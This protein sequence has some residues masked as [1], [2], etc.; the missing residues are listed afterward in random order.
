[1]RHYKVK[2]VRPASFLAVGSK[3]VQCVHCGLSVDGAA[4]KFSGD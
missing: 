1:M 3:G 2:Q 4:E